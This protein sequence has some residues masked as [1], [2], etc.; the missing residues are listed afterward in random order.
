LK[1][2]PLLP[3]STHG[4]AV[5]A[6]AFDTIA[7]VEINQRAGHQAVTESPVLLVE[8]DC[9][10]SRANPPVRREEYRHLF[11]RLRSG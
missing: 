2:I 5:G 4:G 8:E 1:P 7:A 3:P 10:P 9:L 11:S 6:A